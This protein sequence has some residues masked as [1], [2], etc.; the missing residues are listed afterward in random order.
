MA[1]R[2]TNLS[3]RARAFTLI[4]LLVV[5][6]IIA[7]LASMLLPSLVSAKRAAKTAICIGNL[8]Q[9][10]PAVMLYLSDK[11]EFFPGAMWGS[12]W[13][14]T[15]MAPYIGVAHPTGTVTPDK[16]SCYWCPEDSYRNS[17]L[18]TWPWKCHLSYGQNYYMRCDSGVKMRQHSILK[19]PADLIYLADSYAGP[20]SAYPGANVVFS[21]NSWPFLATA[22]P[23]YG[24]AF[25][26]N[27]QKA[28]CLYADFHVASMITANLLGSYAKY[29]YEAP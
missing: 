10:G 25:R 27:G 28:M 12:E 11:E 24:L 8:K 26:H 1:M 20:T 6:S 4:E 9:I 3:S 19:R 13:F 14:F 15:D 29:T 2:K 16:A 17:S 22:T 7:I 5:I 18:P 23:D 21:V